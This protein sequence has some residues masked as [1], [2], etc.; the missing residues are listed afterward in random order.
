MNNPTSHTACHSRGSRSS[1]PKPAPHDGND[2]LLDTFFDHSQQLDSTAL[3]ALL[4]TSFDA[5]DDAFDDATTSTST[6]TSTVKAARHSSHTENNLHQQAPP[7]RS[8]MATFNTGSDMAVQT[9]SP[10]YAFTTVPSHARG[11][12]APSTSTY[13]AMPAHAYQTNMYE[14]SSMTQPLPMRFNPLRH[15]LDHEYQYPGPSGMPSMSDYAPTMIPHQQ[16]QEQQLPFHPAHYV[17]PRQATADL[18]DYDN[19]IP[20]EDEIDE[21]A[22]GEVTDPCY[23]QLLYGCLLEAPD[24]TMSLKDVYSWVCQHSQKARDSTGTGWQNSVRHNLSMNAV[25]YP[26]ASTKSPS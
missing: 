6:S 5:F 22:N 18:L 17:E 11:F 19:T 9:S 15:Q 4:D 3:D 24:H 14:Q 20:E 16:Q 21:N 1:S 12:P 13:H 7:A 8:N 23:A 10:D 25:S 2:I 26:E